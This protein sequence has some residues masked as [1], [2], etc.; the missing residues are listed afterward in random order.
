MRLTMRNRSRRR[1][2]ARSFVALLVS[3]A[4][5]SVAIGD[6]M[7]PDF[8]LT[9]VNS[10]SSTYSQSVSP[11]DYLAHASAWYFGRAT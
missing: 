10:T 9:D 7:V 6:D 5:S 1:F 11:R 3:F 4:G 8:A 2:L